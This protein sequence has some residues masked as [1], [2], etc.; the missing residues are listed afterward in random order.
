M[1]LLESDGFETIDLGLIPDNKDAIEE[2][3]QGGIG[4]C[5]II[6]HYRRSKHG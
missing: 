1:A 4:K 5:D 3:T 2:T 6:N